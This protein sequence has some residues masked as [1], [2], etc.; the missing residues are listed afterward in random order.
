MLNSRLRGNSPWTLIEALPHSLMQPE[1]CGIPLQGKE[2]GRKRQRGKK[3]NLNTVFASAGDTQ[4]HF[5]SIKVYV[6]AGMGANEECFCLET[7]PQ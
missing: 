5:S 4:A 3:T 2:D 6:T 7:K 1:C